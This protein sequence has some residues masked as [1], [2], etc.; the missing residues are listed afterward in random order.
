M[1]ATCL[2]VLPHD[3]EQLDFVLRP[4]RKPYVELI[5]PGYFQDD[6]VCVQP[7][8]K[9]PAAN[10]PLSR[11]GEAFY[12]TMFCALF[13]LLAIQTVIA[14]KLFSTKWHTPPVL[15]PTF[16]ESTSAAT[17]PEIEERFRKITKV[18]AYLLMEP[19][20][21]S[22]G[23]DTVDLPVVTVM[24]EKAYLR[25]GPGKEHA[26]ILAVTKGTRLVAEQ[27]HGEWYQV[28]A[29]NGQSLWVSLQV[30]ESSPASD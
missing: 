30:L 28:V 13:L 10:E 4:D 12:L 2:K 14:A 22:P 3:E 21:A 5:H 7:A 6:D 29:P 16:P 8:G 26:P 24:A 11:S 20:V 19:K 1:K 17:V 23:G 9:S 25:A 27:Q 18:L 15:I